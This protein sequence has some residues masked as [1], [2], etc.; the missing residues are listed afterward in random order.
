MEQGTR[1]EKGLKFNL[2]LIMV[3]VVP[4]FIIALIIT[5]ISISSFRSALRDSFYGPLHTASSQVNEYF[6]YDIIA[7]GTSMPLAPEDAAPYFISTLTPQSFISNATASAACPA[8]SSVYSS[9]M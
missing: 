6:V 3:G 4:A 2:F 5:I 9:C 8:D 1:R 7:N